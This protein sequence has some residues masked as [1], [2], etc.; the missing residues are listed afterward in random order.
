MQLLKLKGRVGLFSPLEGRFA[1]AVPGFSCSTEK[2][3]SRFYPERVVTV[4]FWSN[5]DYRQWQWQWQS[6]TMT[7]R[8]SSSLIPAK[9][10]RLR[11]GPHQRH[12]SG[13]HTAWTD[14]TWTVAFFSPCF[15]ILVT[16]VTHTELKLHPDN[17]QHIK[18]CDG[19]FSDSFQLRYP[20]SDV[21]VS[22]VVILWKMTF[23]PDGDTRWKVKSS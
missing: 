19:T 5:P 2:V 17:R 15:F 16:V 14:G 10:L 23:W 9:L 3:W 18:W 21:N 6:P 13:L 4:M 8:C 12:S 11:S 20:C 7:R 22:F 1:S